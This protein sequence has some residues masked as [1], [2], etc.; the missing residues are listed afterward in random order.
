MSGQI[1]S[2]KSNLLNV[3]SDE[4]LKSLSWALYG[5]FLILSEMLF[6][7]LWPV[8]GAMPALNAAWGFSVLI[9]VLF[10]LCVSRATI[11]EINLPRWA[12]N[13]SFLT[14]GFAS[15]C[16]LD[17]SGLA[18][19]QYI[20]KQQVITGDELLAMTSPESISKL[21]KLISLPR[22]TLVCFLNPYDSSVEEL[23]PAAR[24]I[25]EH[26]KDQNFEL[27]EDEWA[28]VWVSDG[29]FS[30]QILH[31]WNVKLTGFQG[32]PNDDRLP[33]GFAPRQCVEYQHAAFLRIKPVNQVTYDL[34]V[35][36]E[37]S[38]DE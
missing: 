2:S 28:L 8:F 36:G 33:K 20:D 21:Q 12:L 27:Q 1:L 18:L 19:S 23:M 3:P 38:A 9:L 16:L 32:D 6:C 22:D 29:H 13:R 35:F 11:R 37:I 25:N 17:T 10:K 30:A 7:I 34:L 26:L 4:N 14:L 24:V 5:K 15:L 31:L